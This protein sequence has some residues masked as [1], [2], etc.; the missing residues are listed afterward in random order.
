MR[1][2]FGV[3]DMETAKLVSGMLG[4]ETLSYEGTLNQSEAKM[5]KKEIVKSMF[6]GA[7]PFEVSHQLQHLKIAAENQIKQKRELMTPGEILDMPEDEQILFISGKDLPPTLANKCPY[8]SGHALREMAGRYLPNPYHPPAG[9]VKVA[10]W[11]G[12]KWVRII[13]E[14]VPLAFRSFP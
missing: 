12:N 7:D 2:F 14:P 3:R 10:T 11:H 13:S 6:E 8:F 9:K 4:M 1:Q 5:R